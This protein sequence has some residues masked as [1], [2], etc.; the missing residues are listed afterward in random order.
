MKLLSVYWHNILPAFACKPQE[1]K[2]DPSVSMFKDHLRLIAEKYT[3][4]SVS[5]FVNIMDDPRMLRSYNNP[6]ILLGFDDGFRS[7]ITQVLPILQEEKI[8][9]VVFVMGESLRNPE[10]VPW[11]L[12]VAHVFRRTQKRQIAWGGSTF[13]VISRDDCLRFRD[14]FQSAIRTCRSD[15]DREAMLTSIGKSLDVARPTASDLDED[16]RLVTK[17]D[18]ASLGSTSML[19]VASHAMTHRYLDS[20]SHEEQVLELRQSDTLLRELCRAYYPVI[21]YP[22]GAFNDET[23]AIASSIYRAGFG[24]FRGSSFKNRY[25]Y[26]RTGLGYLTADDLNHRISPTTTSFILPLKRILYAAGITTPLKRAL[27]AAGF[28]RS[29]TY[30]GGQSIERLGA[31]PYTE[32]GKPNQSAKDL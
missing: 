16:L 7:I 13:D 32:S 17:D 25:A 28:R 29:E 14:Q 30:L 1:E 24:T 6:P 21:A 12:E 8:P 5:D 27:H 26:P 15:S 23:V 2:L 10:F 18:L 19:T 11:F 3:P 31:D 4:I 9:A 22:G 20:L